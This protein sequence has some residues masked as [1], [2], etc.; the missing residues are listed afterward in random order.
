MKIH[1]RTLLN[2]HTVLMLS[3]TLL[4]V[5]SASALRT[6]RVAS[7]LQRPL[8]VC[9]PPGDSTR[10]FIVEQWTASIKI[11]NLQTNAINPTPFI[12]LNSVTV[13][14][15]NERGLLGMAWD[16]D[17]PDS[18]YFYVH[19]NNNAGNSVI[20][21]YTVSA[22]PDLADSSSGVLILTVIQP[23]GGSFQNHKGGM[24]AFSPLD[25]F[26][27]IGMGD[28]GSG[29]DPGNRAQSDTTR[30]GKFLRL[31]V[32]PLPYTIPVSNP[33][34]TDTNF[35]KRE[36]WC[37]GVRN[38]WR[39]SFDR[40]TGDMYVGD[41]GQGAR[42]EV[43]IETA[44]APGGRNYG[45]RCMEGFLCTGSSGCTCNDPALTL[46]VLDYPHTP[47]CSI[48]GGYVYRGCRIP[49]L[50]GRY[51][52]ADYCSDSI[53]TFLYTGGTVTERMN[54]TV[55]LAPDSAR[56][57][58]DISSFGEDGS[59]ELYLCDLA[60]GEVFKI[61]PDTLADCNGNGCADALDILLG[62]SADVNG[63]EIPDE[64]D[65][66]AIP[67]DDV[68]INAVADSGQ[69][70]IS[71]LAAPGTNERYRVYRSVE[72]DASFP[73]AWTLIADNVVPTIP[74]A[75]TTATDT[76]GASAEVRFYVVTSLCP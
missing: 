3:A 54:R 74:P 7:G 57:I 73:A 19:Y 1:G 47:H 4:S 61:M 59:G 16:P 58:G 53:W 72:L 45:W 2:A 51:V 43:D 62:R 17:W 37:K 31:D 28:G 56:V 22:N 24:I 11:L 41:V 26:L 38:P 64:C 33:W 21:R 44:V 65:C 55:D 48:T 40:V 20:A 9:A 75:S 23:S 18:N 27:Y 71:W 12:D 29:G 39:W 70:R 25:G 67:A 34:A 15:G 63:N 5:D 66:I 69:V 13:G 46:P 35:V 76:I 52:Y 6:N 60:G 32:R 42:E 14:S 68:V 50:Y 36:F 10:L 8:F 49:E 30:L